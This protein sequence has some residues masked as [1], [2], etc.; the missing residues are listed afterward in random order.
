MPKRIRSDSGPE[1]AS[2]HFEAW[3]LEWHIDLLHI[4]LTP[5]AERARGELQWENVRQVLNVSWFCNLFEREQGGTLPTRMQ[6]RPT[7]LRLKIPRPAAF[8]VGDLVSP[9]NLL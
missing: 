6:L 8:A 1:F 9:A 2:R 7:P 3:W 5:T 4:Q